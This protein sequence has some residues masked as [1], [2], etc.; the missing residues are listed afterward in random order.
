MDTSLVD[1]LRFQ[2]MPLVDQGEKYTSDGKEHTLYWSYIQAIILLGYWR[3]GK[4]TQN[5]TE[6]MFVK[7]YMDRMLDNGIDHYVDFR[8]ASTDQLCMA[9]LLLLLYDQW[10]KS[11][12]KEVADRFFQMAERFPRTQAGS[13]WHKQNYPSQIWLDGLYMAQPFLTQYR[14]RFLPQADDT[15]TLKQL[16]LARH[17]LFDEKKRLY[18]HACDTSRKMFWCDPQTGRSAHVWLRA[19]GWLAMALADLYPVI[20]EKSLDSANA[21]SRQLH[22]LV[23]GMLPHRRDGMWYQVVDEEEGEGNYLETSGS[24]MMAYALMRGARLGMLPRFLLGVG[25]DSFESVL[26]QKLHQEKGQVMLEGTCESAGLGRHPETGAI[27]DGSYLYYV[28]KERIVVN[29]GHGIGALF[30]AANEY[31]HTTEEKGTTAK[32]LKDLL[33]KREEEGK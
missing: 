16:E 25:R 5:E 9:N 22:E 29:N 28:R 4:I 27:R 26:R 17:Y 21:L 30:L 15:D 20:M 23:E 19:V 12:Y 31:A 8:Y 10:P 32:D 3:H 6:C 1:V 11:G 2:I 24:L 14:H 33:A 7:R 18:L 13:F